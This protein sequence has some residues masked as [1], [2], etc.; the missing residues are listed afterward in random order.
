MECSDYG[1]L[2]KEIKSKC[3][4]TFSVIQNKFNLETPPHTHTQMT[5][6]YLGGLFPRVKHG[7]SRCATGCQTLQSQ[8]RGGTM[9]GHQ[10]AAV[11]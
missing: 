3:C 8:R 11:S 7:S 2:W 10:P 5:R 4:Q 9:L 6:P 1:I